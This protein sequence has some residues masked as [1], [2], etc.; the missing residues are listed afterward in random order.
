MASSEQLLQ[1]VKQAL[2]KKGITYKQVGAHLDLSE[3][4]V[5]RLFANGDVSLKRLSSVCQLLDWDWLDL[6]QAANQQQQLIEQLSQEQEQQIA[7]D[8]VLLLVAVSIINGFSIDDL[9]QQ[10]DLSEVTCIQKL[11]KLDKL[12]LIELL[13]NNRVRLKISTNFRWRP[14][15]PIQR[16]FLDNVLQEFFDSHFAKKE[17]QLV[18]VNALLSDASNRK[19]Q[20]KIDKLAREM[21]EAMQA[22]SGLPMDEKRGNTLV[23]AIRRWRYAAFDK[24]SKLESE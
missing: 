23:V 7:D 5:K 20:Q 16:F 11:V 17:E 9:Q 2:R 18:V 4:S 6:L 3:A 10:Y 12:Q 1:C 13:P 14:M 19:M 15:G 8:I 22:D 24:L 21:S